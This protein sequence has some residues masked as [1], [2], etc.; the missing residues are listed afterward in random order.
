MVVFSEVR[1]WLKIENEEHPHYVVG[2][3]PNESKDTVVRSWIVDVYYDGHDV[4]LQYSKDGIRNRE[5]AMTVEKLYQAI[6]SLPAKDMDEVEI[7]SWGPEGGLCRIDCPLVGACFFN[8]E[9]ALV[10]NAVQ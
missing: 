8:D 7:S 4:I 9:Q 10:F 5:K 1:E 2:E 3:R 6:Q